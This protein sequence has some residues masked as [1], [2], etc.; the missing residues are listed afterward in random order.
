[1]RVYLTRH[2]HN[3]DTELRIL[4]MIFTQFAKRTSY[5]SSSVAILR[6][7]LVNGRRQVVGGTGLR[8]VCQVN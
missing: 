4:F 8:G 7:Q 6:V 5:A 1:M 2:V 3:T